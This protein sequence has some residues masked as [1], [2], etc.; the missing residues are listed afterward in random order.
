[1]GKGMVWPNMRW[2]TGLWTEDRDVV[3]CC[4]AEN[5]GVTTNTSVSLFSVLTGAFLEVLF[6]STFFSCLRR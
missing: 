6:S 4:G 2:L 3:M 1:M 5:A